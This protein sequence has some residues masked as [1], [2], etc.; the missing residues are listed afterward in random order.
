MV[1]E[2]GVIQQMSKAGEANTA[3]TDMLMPIY[4][5]A[6]LFF[7]VIEVK[8]VQVGETDFPVKLLHG[9]LVPL[10]SADII[11]GSEN[12]AGIQADTDLIGKPGP[13]SDEA[14]LT[15]TASQPGPLPG[16]GFHQNHGIRFCLVDRFVKCTDKPLK[17][18]FGTIAGVGTRMYDN[19]R[20]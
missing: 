20:Y 4:P 15:E 12:V 10:C 18:T 6:K 5:A 13:A 11:T 14:E 16:G 8:E 7:G 19:K 2:S 9:L 1:L 3:L 17:P